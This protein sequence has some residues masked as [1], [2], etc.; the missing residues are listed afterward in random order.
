MGEEETMA[1]YEVTYTES[2]VGG[3]MVEAANEEEAAEIVKNDIFEGRR[4][5]PDTCYDSSCTVTKF[6]KK[7]KRF[8]RA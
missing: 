2:Y 8:K 5:A 4:H 1:I 6:T 3:Y 7:E